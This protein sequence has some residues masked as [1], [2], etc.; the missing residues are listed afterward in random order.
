MLNNPNMQNIPVRTEQ[1]C[2]IREAFIPTKSPQPEFDFAD[3]E[4]RALANHLIMT[5]KKLT[6]K[7]EKTFGGGTFYSADCPYC[8]KIKILSSELNSMS[9]VCNKCY[10]PFKLEK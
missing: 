7:I 4:I 8:G 6:A 3:V 5:D 10:Q 1:G 2:K 9:A